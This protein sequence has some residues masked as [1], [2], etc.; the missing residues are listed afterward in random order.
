MALVEGDIDAQLILEQ[1]IEAGA[2]PVLPLDAQGLHYLLSTPFRYQARPPAGSRFRASHDGAVFYGAED[3]RTAC[4]EAG[5]WRLKFWT[6]S[7]GLAGQTASMEMSLFE[8]HA[9]S[10]AALDLTLPPLVKEREEWTHPTDYTPTQSLA[11]A[12]RERGAQMIRY[13]S[14]RNAPDGRCLAILSPAVFKA[15]AR[16]FRHK[17]QTWNLFIR[18]PGEVV[19]RRQFSDEAFV[20]RY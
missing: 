12:A 11:R 4:A 3:V 14:V 17:I 10:E 7:A 5:Y 13:E 9:A 19:W 16:P 6:D 20:C 8:F 15:V 1:I 18:P 2:K